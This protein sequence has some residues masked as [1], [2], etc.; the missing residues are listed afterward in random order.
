MSFIRPAQAC[1]HSPTSGLVGRRACSCCMAWE[2]SGKGVVGVASKALWSTPAS[3]QKE[4]T[5]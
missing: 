3:S 4:G 2:V 1:H 5:M